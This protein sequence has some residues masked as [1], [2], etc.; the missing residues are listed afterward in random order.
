MEKEADWE[1]ARAEEMEVV[2]TVE[3]RVGAMVGER[4]GVKVVVMAG[5]VTVGAERV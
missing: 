1:E 4:V 2:A 3:E 5:A